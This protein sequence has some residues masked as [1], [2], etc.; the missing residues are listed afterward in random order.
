MH[1]I[2]FGARERAADVGVSSLA[3]AELLALVLG[4]G[5]PGEPVGM[6]AQSML[7]ELGGVEG[8]ARAGI[9]ELTET[10]GLGLARGARVAA[11]TELGRRAY[12]ASSRRDG[13]SFAD[14]TAVDAWARPR[15]VTLD[16]EELWALALDGRNRL[17]AARRIAAGGLH[18]LHVLPRDVLRAMLREAASTFVLVHNHPSGDS[19]PSEEDV[20][21]TMRIVEAARV[22]ATP[23]VDHVVI[24]APGYTSMLEAGILK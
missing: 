2:S 17:R 5:N 10:R 14:A 20:G 7:E 15:L 11:A 8:I 18:G 1:R 3:D 9:G 22:V 12:A 23:L 24:G 4:T 21:F 6:L 13:A 16:H 19:Q